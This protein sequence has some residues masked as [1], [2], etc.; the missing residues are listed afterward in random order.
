M[1]GS[2]IQ[3]NNQAGAAYNYFGNFKSLK[4]LRYLYLLPLLI[5]LVN[6]SVYNTELKASERR[7]KFPL[8]FLPVS[9][10]ISKSTHSSTSDPKVGGAKFPFQPNILIHFSSVLRT[11]RRKKKPF[12][13]LG[14]EVQSGYYLNF[15]WIT[16]DSVAISRPEN[17]SLNKMQLLCLF[18][19]RFSRVKQQDSRTV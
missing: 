15:Q 12:H 9:T 18:N 5:C 10:Y 14:G 1:T 2:M 11:R 4:I 8:P 6:R 7:K 13:V 17:H 16:A 19:L 3:K